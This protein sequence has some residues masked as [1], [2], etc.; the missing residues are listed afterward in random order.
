M[1]NYYNCLF[2]NTNG[3]A[4]KKIDHLAT[5]FTVLILAILKVRTDLRV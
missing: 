1:F 3:K 2:L 5:I 4:K